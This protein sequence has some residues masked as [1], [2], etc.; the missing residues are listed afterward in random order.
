M[1]EPPDTELVST[2]CSV[3]GHGWMC[4]G[5]SS[6]EIENS[7]MKMV[8]TFDWERNCG[9]MPAESAARLAE[10]GGQK[11]AS[12]AISVLCVNST[13]HRLGSN[14]GLAYFAETYMVMAKAKDS[15]H[16]LT[17]GSTSKPKPLQA[18]DGDGW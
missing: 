11:R 9:S 12:Y 14:S 7:D 5:S 4:A 13:T 16:P 6:D 1:R 2:S 18:E 8:S 17:D 3:T 10:E 15:F